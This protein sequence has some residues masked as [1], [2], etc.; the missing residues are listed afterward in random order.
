MISYKPNS[1]LFKKNTQK[2]M[3]VFKGVNY[4]KIIKKSKKNKITKKSKKSKKKKT[5]KKRKKK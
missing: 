5:T 4:E 2:N 1:K 3:L